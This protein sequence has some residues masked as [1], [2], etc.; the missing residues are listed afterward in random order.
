MLTAS[1]D[2]VT[3]RQKNIKK[4][5]IPSFMKEAL[6]TAQNKDFIRGSLG[7]GSV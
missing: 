4:Y 1:L 3:L 6:D 5:L 7:Y 2:D